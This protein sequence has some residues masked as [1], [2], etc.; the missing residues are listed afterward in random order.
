MNE[1]EDTLSEMKAA[2]YEAMA[3]INRSFEQIISAIYKL[4]P[5]GIASLGYVHSQEVITSEIW[6]KI[7]C[8]ML[9]RISKRELEDRNHYKRMRVDLDKRKK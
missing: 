9:A 1:P 3:L 7:N 8:Q 4:E 6:A 2:V 5:L